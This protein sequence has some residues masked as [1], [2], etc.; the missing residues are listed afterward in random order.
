MAKVLFMPA[1]DLIIAADPFPLITPAG[2]FNGTS[3]KTAL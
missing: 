3:L 2:P 1:I